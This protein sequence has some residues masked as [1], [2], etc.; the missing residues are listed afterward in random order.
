MK[1]CK[2]P[3]MSPQI[4][5]IQ[6]I[7]AA[8]DNKMNFRECLVAIWNFSFMLKIQSIWKIMSRLQNPEVVCR[9][10]TSRISI[11]R[12]FSFFFWFQSCLVIHKPRRRTFLSSQET[13]FFFLLR[14]K[15]LRFK[16]ACTDGRAIAIAIGVCVRIQGRNTK[17]YFI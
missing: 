8:T 2:P 15:K 9:Q 4:K 1:Y 17:V 7:W 14:Q 5:L 11:H 12:L 3:S 10:E 13:S 6:L 16:H